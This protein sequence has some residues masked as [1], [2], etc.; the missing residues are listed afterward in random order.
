MLLVLVKFFV[1]AFAIGFAWAFVVCIFA[2]Y[3]DSPSKDRIIRENG[4][5]SCVYDILHFGK[6]WDREKHKYID[7]EVKVKTE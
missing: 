2:T 6:Y 5:D 7:V 4:Y 3:A 1:A